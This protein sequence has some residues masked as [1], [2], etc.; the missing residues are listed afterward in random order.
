MDLLIGGKR[1]HDAGGKTNIQTTKELSDEGEFSLRVRDSDRR[2]KVTGLVN[3][4]DL[5]QNQ[6]MA[7][8]IQIS[9]LYKHFVFR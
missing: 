8:L 9:L 6:D 4:F 1:F 3:L 7:I 5:F 2:K